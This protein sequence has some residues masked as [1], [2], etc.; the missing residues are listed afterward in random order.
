MHIRLGNNYMVKEDGMTFR[1]WTIP[2][3][4]VWQGSLHIRPFAILS[5]AL[6]LALSGT[7]AAPGAAE[8][9]G[10]SLRFDS[11]PASASVTSGTANRNVVKVKASGIAQKRIR[12]AISGNS[13]FSITPKG[14]RVMYN[15][16]SISGASVRLTVTASD[17]RGKAQS[18]SHTLKVNNLGYVQ[19]TPAPKPNPTPTPTPTPN[20][21][22]NPV[23]KGD[24]SVGM[25]LNVGD[26]CTQNGVDFSD[27]YGGPD[28]WGPTVKVY[29]HSDGTARFQYKCWVFATCTRVSSVSLSMRGLVIEKKQGRW[30]ITSV[31]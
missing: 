8:A 7:L 19:P 10:K 28:G 12:Y 5:F 26:S 15:G 17:R 2:T 29:I 22:P 1:R 21:N 3:S 14:G 25:V 9:Q 6:I 16:S 20:P 31:P 4:G 23:H 11:P 13:A 27:A 24:C 30:T 18:A